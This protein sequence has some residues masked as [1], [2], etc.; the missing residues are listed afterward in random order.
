MCGKTWMACTEPWPQFH[1]ATLEKKNWDSSFY[2]TSG[3]HCSHVPNLFGNVV[4]IIIN[5]AYLYSRCTSR[6]RDA[7]NNNPKCCWAVVWCNVMQYQK[8]AELEPA[9]E[10]CIISSLDRKCQTDFAFGGSCHF[11]TEIGPFG[12]QQSALKLSHSGNVTCHTHL[13]SASAVCI[14]SV[15]PCGPVL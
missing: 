9:L 7:Q 6:M 10:T 15:W 1:P 5:K 2:P 13:L 14:S 8:R 3:Y 4:Y 12:E 11:K